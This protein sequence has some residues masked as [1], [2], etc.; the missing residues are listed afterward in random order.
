MIDSGLKIDLDARELRLLITQRSS[1]NEVISN[2]ELPIQTTIH[3][4]F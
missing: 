4:L 3:E 1:F 2:A